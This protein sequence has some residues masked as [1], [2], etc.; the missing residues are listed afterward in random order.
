MDEAEVVMV[1][2]TGVA[3]VVGVTVVSTTEVL[4]VVEGQPAQ[5]PLLLEDMEEEELEELEVLDEDEEEEDLD[6]VVAVV[7]VV[8]DEEDEE[9]ELPWRIEN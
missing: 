2:G 5:L 7:V 3:L 6:D 1:T 8:V 4:T 9:Q